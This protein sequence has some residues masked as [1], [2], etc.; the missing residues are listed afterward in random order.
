MAGT[1]GITPAG[2]SLKPFS[3]LL[4]ALQNSWLANVDPTAD[5]SATTPEGQILNLIAND[6]QELWGLAQAGWNAFNREDV[7]GAG[8]DNLGDLNGDPREGPSYTQ[9]ICTLGL[10]PA[11]APYGAG[12]LVANVQGDSA[13]TFSNKAAVTVGMISGGIATGILMQAQTIGATPTINPNTLNHITSAVTGWSSINNPSAQSQLGTNEET[14]NAYVIRQQQE[15]GNEGAN[16]A[17]SLAGQLIALGAAQSPPITL[18]VEVLENYSDATI[19][20]GTVTLP[21]HTFAPIVYDP[22]STLTAAQI[23]QI[24]YNNTPPGITSVGTTSV[25]V[26]DPNLGPQTAFYTAPTPEPLFITAVIVLRNGFTLAGVTADIQNALVQAAIAPTPPG[27]TAPVG[28]LLPGS[29]VLE[30]QLGGVIVAVPGVFDVQLVFFDFVPNPA[31]F[32]PLLVDPTH[33]ATIS[34]ANVTVLTGSYP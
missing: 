28:Q 14:D 25:S 23:G 34:A 12:T 13:L 19:S 4:L 11:H 20:I 31:Q 18:S 22:T 3:S 6:D 26:T 5:L 21:P 24:V 8:L 27:G 1:F 7:E 9:V 15:L 10:D 33:I 29:P 2:F 32:F 17:S 16:N 30:S